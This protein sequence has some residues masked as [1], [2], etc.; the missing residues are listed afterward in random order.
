MKNFVLSYYVEFSNQL[1]IYTVN[2]TVNSKNTCEEIN[3]GKTF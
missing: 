3:N 1:K 2:N